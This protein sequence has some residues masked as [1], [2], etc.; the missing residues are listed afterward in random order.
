ME[1]HSLVTRQ[2]QL[3]VLNEVLSGYR[4][5]TTPVKWQ[6]KRVPLHTLIATQD[7]VEADKYQQ[8]KKLVAEGK[9]DVPIL[10]EEH[11]VEGRYRRYVIDGHCRTRALI[12]IGKRTTD[13]FVIWSPAG[14]F[15][16]NFVNVAQQYG[17][18]P[19]RD[20]PFC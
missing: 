15:Q 13:A 11:Y 14:D 8:V 7:A 4:K 1:R 16:S 17:D 19:V 18:V 5:L 2:R 20:L 12:E 3:A 9:L 6:E 10:V